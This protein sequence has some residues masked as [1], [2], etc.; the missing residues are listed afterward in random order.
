[1]KMLIA[2]DRGSEMEAMMRSPAPSISLR[3]SLLQLPGELAVEA[4]SC[5]PG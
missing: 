5:I 2:G 1:M 3:H 4:H